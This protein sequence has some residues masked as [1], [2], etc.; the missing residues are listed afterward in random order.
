[1]SS[2]KKKPNPRWDTLFE[3][4]PDSID[5]TPR[6]T[7]PPYMP[8]GPA[9][10]YH[11][12]GSRALGQM[13]PRPAPRPLY[14]RFSLEKHLNS[15][16]VNEW[17]ESGRRDKLKKHRDSLWEFIAP[18]VSFEFSN[19]VHGSRTKGL[20]GPRG[21]RGHWTAEQM[22]D[23]YIAQPSLYFMSEQGPRRIETQE[24]PSKDFQWPGRFDHNFWFTLVGL[25]YSDPHRQSIKVIRFH[26]GVQ[27]GLWMEKNP[28]R[29]WEKQWYIRPLTFSLG[30]QDISANVI[31]AVA[32]SDNAVGSTECFVQ[33]NS[34]YPHPSHSV[35]IPGLC[36]R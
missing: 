26:D 5:T 6:P 36:Q 18:A 11:Q 1:M 35:F 33:T 34:R 19:W 14:P 7:D 3:P 30:G 25:V 22:F 21:R 24:V 9:A 12:E 4:E 23:A 16:R 15:V 2:L 27:A 17:I 10:L 28:Q 29:S 31:K 32:E 20:K 13:P 8:S